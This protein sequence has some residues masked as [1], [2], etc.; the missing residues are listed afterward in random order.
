MSQTTATANL[1]SLASNATITCN[2]GEI[3]GDTF[4]YSTTIIGTAT[5][6][7]YQLYVELIR[8]Q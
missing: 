6:F 3:G 5:G 7:Q 4:R 1:L 8:Q 2:F